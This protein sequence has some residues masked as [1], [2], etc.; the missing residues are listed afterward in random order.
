MIPP[1]IPPLRPRLLSRFARLACWASA[2]A[3]A[4]PAFAAEPS[5]A[6][7]PPRLVP[8]D[9][10]AAQHTLHVSATARP[11]GD[12]SQA[13]PF[14]A[15]QPAVEAA[16][17]SGKASRVL[18]GP[19]TYRETIDIA[20]SSGAPAP[21]LILQAERAGE[22]IVSGSDLFTAWKP[23]ADSPGRFEHA[24]PHKLG[25]ERN[26][27]PGLMP[28][29][30]PGLRSEL[31][32][33]D[34][35]PLR[36]VFTEDKLAAN[37]YWVDEDGSRIVLALDPGADPARHRIEVSVRPIPRQGTHSKLLRIM[38]RDNV[39]VR[40]L[41]FRHGTTPAFVAA[42]QILASNNIL[43]EDVRSEWNSGAGVG[44]A[45]FRGKIGSNIVF[46]RVHL[47]HN[48][49]MGL[50]GSAHDAL[51]EDISTDYNNWRGVA[52][53]ATGWAPC[54]WKLSHLERVV[55]RRV[56]SIGNHASGG[57]LDDVIH[58]VLIEDFVGLNNY[59]SGLSVEAVEGPLEIRG[60]FLAGNSTGLNLFDSR[61]MTLRD[62][63]VT[64]NTTSQI[65][66]AGSLPLT[67]EALARITPNWR[68]ERLSKRMIP[69][70]IVLRDNLVG[71]TRPDDEAY[72]RARLITVGMRENAFLAHGEPTLEPMFRSLL[73]S[74][75]RYAW[76]PSRPD[77]AFSDHL[78][79]PIDL[80]AWQELTGQDA[81][82]RLAPEEV[83][84]AQRERAAALGVSIRPYDVRSA[85]PTSSQADV[86]EL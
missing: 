86:L 17:R 67:T 29:D 62:S 19:G 1:R 45:S 38:Q 68:R 85:S 40:G 44:L 18:I 31:L 28:L 11:G 48:G 78:N 9:E 43:L 27:W 35:R 64:D 61:S 37:S 13:R 12:G 84:T 2:L 10:A 79:R 74:G 33:V 7:D 63:I 77:Q 16:L 76:A 70:D 46:R 39:V 42:V 6:I 73:S 54:G 22:T 56:R 8:L 26:P 5:R 34:Q 49:F 53:G 47:D 25:W 36:Q 75:N 21:L 32:F 14:A 59:R 82:A 20:G 66:L 83:A 65:R 57:W 30:A 4:A 24:W 80:A 71:L 55:L 69:T 23:L 15:I 72:A 52:V 81:D 60:A 50:T 3:A 41:V 51:F 58:H